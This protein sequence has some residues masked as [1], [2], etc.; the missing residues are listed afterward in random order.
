[1][2]LSAG[3]RAAIVCLML[4]IGAMP[5]LAQDVRYFQVCQA[6]SKSTTCGSPDDFVISL[7]DPTKIQMAEKIANGVVKDGT[8]INGKI[9]AQPAEYN[10]PWKFYLDPGSITFFTLAPTVCGRSLTTPAIDAN[11]K[12]VGTPNFLPTGYWCPLKYRVYKEIQPR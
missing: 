4:N 5:C 3:R 9:V 11:L 10:R 6:S 8:H 1:M 7:T 2:N 12:K